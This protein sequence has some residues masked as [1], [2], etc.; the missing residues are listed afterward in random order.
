MRGTFKLVE[1]KKMM[2]QIVLHMTVE[3]MEGIYHALENRWPG[4]GLRQIL[5]EIVNQVSKS[6]IADGKPPEDP[7]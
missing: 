7:E 4:S 1:P 3:E 5:G 2:A 6:V